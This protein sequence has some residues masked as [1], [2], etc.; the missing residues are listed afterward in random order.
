MKKFSQCHLLFGRSIL[1]ENQLRGK[2]NNNHCLLHA[3]SSKGGKGR[4]TETHVNHL[5]GKDG[6]TDELGKQSEAEE[7][8]GV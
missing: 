7:G 4:E 1:K 8:R 6:T 5:W 3:Q 2:N